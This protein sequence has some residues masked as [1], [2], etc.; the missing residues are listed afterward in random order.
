MTGATYDTRVNDHYTPGDLD[1]AFRRVLRGWGKGEGPLTPADLAPL[2]QFHT[3]GLDATLALARLAAV[4]SDDRVIDLGGGFGGPARVLAER[5]GCA[6]TVLD[7]TA[8]YCRVGGELTARCGL[9]DKSPS[10]TA[11]RSPRRSRTARSTSPGRS[12]PR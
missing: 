6:V 12:T 8:A 2:D 9:G 7:L 3:G 10:G 1:A 5:C 4:T 11:T